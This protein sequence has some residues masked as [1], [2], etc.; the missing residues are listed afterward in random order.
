MA[1]TSWKRGAPMSSSRLSGSSGPRKSELASACARQANPCTSRLTPVKGSGL[2][3]A[4][5]YDI[6]RYIL[7]YELD[8]SE[9]VMSVYTRS[10]LESLVCSYFQEGG[11]GWLKELG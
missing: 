3:L 5:G 11:D 1:K 6:L 2:T 7:G 10:E 4:E 9:A 8:D